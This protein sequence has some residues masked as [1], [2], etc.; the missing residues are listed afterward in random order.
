MLFLTTA[1]VLDPIPPALRDR[2]EVLELP[3]YTEEE[4]LQIAERHL[5][6]KQI[7]ENGLGNI[8]IEFTTGTG[9]KSSAATRARRALRNLER[10]IGRVC[11]KI[12][13]ALT[14]GE[15][16]PSALRRSML[17]RFLGPRKFFSEA[18]ERTQEPGVATG[19]AWTPNGGDILFI[20]STR[21]NGQKGVHH[22]RARWAT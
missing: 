1:N 22:H 13:R 14:E 12:A 17:H 10:E 18:A 21:M 3:G 5:V 11:R 6:P 2:M 7:S 16:P 9:P 8:K 15:T 19:L 20:E 4:K